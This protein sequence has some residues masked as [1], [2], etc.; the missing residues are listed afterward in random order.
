M[1][2]IFFN[3]RPE[4]LKL[5]G[6]Q[7]YHHVCNIVPKAD[8]LLTGLRHWLTTGH[9]TIDKRLHIVS[10]N[11]PITW[12]L[13]IAIEPQLGPRLVTPKK[14]IGRSQ[15]FHPNLDAF[16]FSSSLGSMIFRLLEL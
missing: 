6:A 8:A 15:Q 11:E 7:M 3:D 1:R 16:K 9:W 10:S 2:A 4:Y 14:E 5:N 12:Y 13:Q